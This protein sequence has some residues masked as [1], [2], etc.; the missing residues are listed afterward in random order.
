M[1]S[2]NLK[3]ELKDAREI[4]YARDVLRGEVLV[5]TS[6]KVMCNGLKVQLLWR[7]HGHGNRDSS[8]VT[9]KTLYVG[10]WEANET[11]RFPFELT[12]EH[13]PTTYRGHFLN[14]DYYLHATV[15][16]P[17]AFD[18]STERVLI[19]GWREGDDCIPR[20]FC[21]ANTNAINIG[22]SRPLTPFRGFAKLAGR[23]A[24][25]VS[26]QELQ[27]QL[28][29]LAPSE[30]RFGCAAWFEAGCILIVTGIIGAMM[31]S[32]LAHGFG[33]VAYLGLIPISFGL[34][35]SFYNALRSLAKKYIGIPEIRI[36][37]ARAL[38]AGSA[39][40]AHMTLTPTA[41]INVNK[42]TATLV[43]KEVCIGRNGKQTAIRTHKFVEQRITLSDV[44]ALHKGDSTPLSAQF[45]LPDDAP[46]SFPGV[47][48]KVV[49]T[50]AFHIDISYLPALD[51]VSPLFVLP[52]PVASSMV[53]VLT[54][55]VPATPTVARP[56]ADGLIEDLAT[57]TASLIGAGAKFD[58]DSILRKC[59]H[60]HYDFA[61]LVE[62]QSQT[63][64]LDAGP[65]WRGGRAVQ[66]QIAGSGMNIIVRMPADL[67]AEVEQL[68][69]G[70]EVQVKGRIVG[71]DESSRQ[72]IFEAE[73]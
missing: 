34:L 51:L 57:V 21:G 37:P 1:A 43:G 9:E 46:M 59:G 22:D 47:F 64:A 5:E 13:G 56:A 60:K 29:R 58:R 50:L 27:E 66:G 20:L 26:K 62:S 42:V 33:A 32:A 65:A 3:I 8:I 71:F 36:E 40:T 19:V 15:D 18:P 23:S 24:A 10:N 61:L 44:I 63:S 17:W 25:S 6:A 49:W 35:G 72:I 11:L 4:Y 53:K 69:E 70:D 38:T 12:L 68:Q 55:P 48:N 52:P 39:L 45:Q 73:L 67:N 41:N 16:I 31:V 7:T 2:C 54:G 28:E 30:V 14:L